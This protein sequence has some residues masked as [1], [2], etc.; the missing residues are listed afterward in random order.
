MIPTIDKVK[1]GKNIKELMN[2]KHITPNDVME[3]LHLSCVQT[4]YRWFEGVNIPSIDNLYALSCL[5]RVSMDDLVVGMYGDK[6]IARKHLILLRLKRYCN[7]M[8]K[9]RA[10]KFA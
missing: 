7:E 8:Q 9:F 1:T 4:V 6:E 2:K 5:L 3:Y 10:P